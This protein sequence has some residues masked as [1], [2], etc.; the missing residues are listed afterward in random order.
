MAL[1]GLIW[2]P[3]ASRAAGVPERILRQCREKAQKMR[4]TSVSYK[5]G[6]LIMDNTRSS[7]RIREYCSSEIA[8]GCFRHTTATY[9]YGI[10]DY[11]KYDVEDYTCVVPKLYAD[12][13]WVDA[14]IFVKKEYNACQG[15]VVLRH[16]LQ[17]FTIWKTA[18]NNILTESK[19]V[20]QELALS[21][22]QVFSLGKT[23]T[24]RGM[25]SL[26]EEMGRYLKNVN[27]K[28]NDIARKN[29]ALLDKI[30]HNMD[31]EVNYRVCM[32]YSIKLW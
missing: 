31:T 29:D 1:I 24:F 17:H 26:S 30:D 12:Y 15:R 19:R 13:S 14:K 25:F 4:L 10:S 11:L 22:I 7:D 20:L 16:E 18:Q 5:F 32:P 8:A 6:K 27:S 2:V 23:D 28:W 3:S 21:N 9:Q